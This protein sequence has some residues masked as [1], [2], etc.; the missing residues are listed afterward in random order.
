MQNTEYYQSAFVQVNIFLFCFFISGFHFIAQLTVTC[1]IVPTH[2]VPKRRD[3]GI[4]TRRYPGRFSN[5]T[6]IEACKLQNV[7]IATIQSFRKAANLV[8]CVLYDIKVL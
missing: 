1:Q 5:G 2:T 4:V 7:C 3:G 6:A 8:D